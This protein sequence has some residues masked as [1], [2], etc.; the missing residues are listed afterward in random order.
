MKDMLFVDDFVL[1]VVINEAIV[2]VQCGM[3]IYLV[4]TR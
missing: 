2:S 1:I 3:D 4:F